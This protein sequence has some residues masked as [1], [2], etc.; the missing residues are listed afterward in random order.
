MKFGKLAL[1][2][3]IASACFAGSAFGQQGHVSPYKTVSYSDSSS[4]GC[5]PA[6]SS[7]CDVGC[8]DGSCDSAGCDSC[9][10]GSGLGLGLLG[11]LGECCLGEPWALCEEGIC[12]WDIGGWTAVGYHNR[13][14]AQF[15]SYRDRVQLSQQWFYA[16]KVADGSCGLGFGGRIDYLYGTDAPDTQAF[17]IPNNHWDNSWDNAPGGAYGHALPQVYGEVAYGKLSAKVGHFFTIIGNEVVAA[18]GNFFYSRQFTFYNSEPFT[19]TGVL[20]NYQLDDDTNIWNGYVMGWDSG[21]E[22]NGDAY[23]GG[24]SRNLNEYQTLICTGAFGRFGDSPAAG[25]S[26]R[27]INVSSI[28][29]TS[30]TDKLTH[31]VQTDYLDTDNGFAGGTAR[32]TYGNINYLIYQMSDCLAFGQ[33]FEYYNISGTAFTAPKNADTYNYTMGFNYKP[34]ANLV[35]RPEIRFIWDRERVGLISDPDANGNTRSSLAVFGNDLVLS[36]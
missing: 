19:H 36:Y 14:T 13:N 34:T 25:N 21:F 17:G 3:V 27:G 10:C 11:G 29:T 5:A 2:A 18:T 24:F 33:R 20:T 26:E 8:S 15:D 28:L 7:S 22:D 1:S 31:I 12:G 35:W 23:L 6:T 16:E 32:N 4:C 9:G 30:L